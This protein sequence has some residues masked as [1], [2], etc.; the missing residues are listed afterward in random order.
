MEMDP[1]QRERTADAVLFLEQLATGLLYNDQILFG[2]SLPSLW[3]ARDI[4]RERTLFFSGHRLLKFKL[5]GNFNVTTNLGDYQ[6][7]RKAVHKNTFNKKRFVKCQ[8]F[9][10]LSF[11]FSV[12]CSCVLVTVKHRWDWIWKSWHGLFSKHYGDY[13]NRISNV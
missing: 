2:V 10:N 4:L 7:G 3:N 13:K 5:Y 8:H 1:I 12:P 11:I 6:L 9:A